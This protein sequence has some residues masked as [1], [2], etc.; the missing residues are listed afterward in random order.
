MSMLTQL[1]I[2][3]TVFIQFV[4]YIAIFSFL[5]I[6]VFGPYANAV[7]VRESKTK[8]SEELAIEFA[9]KTTE[10]HSEYEKKAREVHGHI[11]EIYRQLKQEAMTE[12]E[13][14]VSKAR[15]ES[16]KTLEENRKTL[17][18][19][20]AATTAELK[21]ETTNISLVITNKLLGK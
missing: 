9:K 19:A 4:I 7:E 18:T 6:Y 16:Q 15:A 20:L 12:S 1:G 10:L 21:A 14:L 5:S 8:G 13:K 2:N 3:Q 11:Q 17:H